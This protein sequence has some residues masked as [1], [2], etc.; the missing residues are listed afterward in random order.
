M[1]VKKKGAK[2]MR[3][4][5]FDVSDNETNYM[6]CVTLKHKLHMEKVTINKSQQRRSLDNDFGRTAHFRKSYTAPNKYLNQLHATNK[7]PESL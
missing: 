1:K 6:P 3:G 4:E 7:P 5:S 2:L